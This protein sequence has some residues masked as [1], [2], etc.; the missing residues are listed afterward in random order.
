MEETEPQA[1]GVILPLQGESLLVNK[2]TQ[3]KGKLRSRVIFNSDI[4]Y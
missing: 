1:A 3:E 2:T 4:I